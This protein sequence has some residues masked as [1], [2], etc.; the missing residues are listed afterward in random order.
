MT[1]MSAAPAGPDRP[2]RTLLILDDAGDPGLTTPQ[3]VAAAGEYGTKAAMSWYGSI[4]RAAD[5]RGWVMRLGRD[6]GGWQSGSPIRWRI[7]DDGRDRLAVYDVLRAVP[8]VRRAAVA[9]REERRQDWAARQVL[10][11]DVRR[12]ADDP[13]TLPREQKL[14][15]AQD[16]RAA[17]CTLQEIGDLFGKSREW[18]RLVLKHGTWSVTT[19][20]MRE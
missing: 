19:A 13:D 1:S 12:L 14:R 3:I 17:G 7:T 10:L 5:K 20:M 18:I 15:L 9:R 11:D 8:T 4:L 16:L 2:R 6:K